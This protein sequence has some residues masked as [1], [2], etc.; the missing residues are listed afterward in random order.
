TSRS[1]QDAL[2]EAVQLGLPSTIADLCELA[3][4]PSVSWDGFDRAEVMRSADAVK[5]LLEQLG[6]FERVQVS[7]API[8]SGSDDGASPG[9]TDSRPQGQPAVLA[10]RAA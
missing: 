1:V 10:T 3:R 7:S 9:G 6:V 2:R 4:I 5:R 8:G